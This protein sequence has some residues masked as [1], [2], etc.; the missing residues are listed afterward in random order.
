MVN[1]G[2]VLVPSTELKICGRKVGAF[3]RVT[4]SELCKPRETKFE[5]VFG[6]CPDHLE[7]LVMPE[8]WNVGWT[9]NG[10]ASG[11]GWFNNGI[12][13]NLRGLVESVVVVDGPVDVKQERALRQMAAFKADIKRI[14]G[15]E[16]A[17][18]LTLDH[19]RTAFEE[20]LQDMTVKDVMD[21]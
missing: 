20:I 13:K 11:G 2:G 12:M 4:Y 14:M 17:K 19:W 9:K 1:K 21:A 8:P 5:D 15:Q 16:N 18:G 3:V 10:W 7:D 6:L